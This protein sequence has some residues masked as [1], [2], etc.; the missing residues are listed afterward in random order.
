MARRFAG[1]ATPSEAYDVKDLTLE[2]FKQILTEPEFR[3]WPDARIA[4]Q[5]YL[6]DTPGDLDGLTA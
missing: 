2:L 1:A 5:A 6:R 4:I 3:D